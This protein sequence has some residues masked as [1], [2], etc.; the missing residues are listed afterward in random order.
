MITDIANGR[1]DRDAVS[2][3]STSAGM[4]PMGEED[5][6]ELVDKVYNNIKIEE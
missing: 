5:I 6:Q 3:F 1:F 2:M 4:T